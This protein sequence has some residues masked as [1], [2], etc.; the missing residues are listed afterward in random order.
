M[1]A[2]IELEVLFKQFC[3]MQ[4]VTASEVFQIKSS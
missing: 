3:V 4:I 2:L 1:A